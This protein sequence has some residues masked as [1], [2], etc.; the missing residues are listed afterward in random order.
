MQVKGRW[1]LIA[2]LIPLVAALSLNSAFTEEDE[3]EYPGLAAA[4]EGADYVGTEGCLMCHADMTEWWSKN[5]HSLSEA[6]DY[7]KIEPA[8]RGCEACHGP[9]SRHTEG[10]LLAIG[11]F[12]YAETTEADDVCLKCHDD[13]VFESDYEETS[14]V[15]AGV[16][17]VDCHNP[18][19]L[20]NKNNLRDKPNELCFSCHQTKRTDFSR[21][22]HHPI[23]K[24]DMRSGLE[25]AECHELHGSDNMSML[26]VARENLC[27]ECHADKQ[28]PYVYSH[29]GYD[30]AL[31]DGCYTCH[32]YHGTNSPNLLL[33][34]GRG[35][36]LQC[37]T[38]QLSHG[39]ARTCWS[40]GCH[41]E[42]HGSNESFFFFDR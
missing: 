1:L 29:A 5:V 28:G 39:G 23:N 9:G 7:D 38:D 30:P 25:C 22:S 26:K 8:M 35:I 16:G 34:S 42:H 37:H 14:H 19:D 31:G 2:F 40:A 21:L 20:T 15:I 41:S 17:C 4:T 18:H 6:R 32:G 27:M 10:D 36:C 11:V 13:M 24:D 33:M 12:E 3:V